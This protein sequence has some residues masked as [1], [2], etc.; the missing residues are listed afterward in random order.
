M[1]LMGIL[2][3]LR[4]PLALWLAIAGIFLLALLAGFAG[5]MVMIVVPV[6]VAVTVVGVIFYGVLYG[7]G[8]VFH[9]IRL[10]KAYRRWARSQVQ[11]AKAKAQTPQALPVIPAPS[12]EDAL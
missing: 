8:S 2:F 1:K 11:G 7:S 9:I 4:A 3:F 12:L 5:I 6:F 10:Q